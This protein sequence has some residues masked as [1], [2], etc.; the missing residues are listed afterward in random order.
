MPLLVGS[1]GGAIE[2]FAKVAF[3]SVYRAS[4][5]CFTNYASFRR[6]TPRNDRMS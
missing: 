3:D 1:G 2:Y 4:S 6:L 5:L